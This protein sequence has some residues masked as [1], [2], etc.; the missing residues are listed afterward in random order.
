MR[1]IY[2]PSVQTLTFS[3]QFQH[4]CCTLY[5]DHGHLCCRVSASP[6]FPKCHL[7]LSSCFYF[8][9]STN[10]SRCAVFECG[11]FC[12]I[13]VCNSIHLSASQWLGLSLWLNNNPFSLFNHSLI[14]IG[15]DWIFSLLWLVCSIITMCK[16]DSFIY[17]PKAIKLGSV[18]VVFLLG[19]SDSFFP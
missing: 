18:V 5:T 12:F 15:A 13:M 14:G 19:G 3:G 7:I 2:I 6:P 10:E 4:A 16:F 1:S 17:I 9:D 11:S 8:L